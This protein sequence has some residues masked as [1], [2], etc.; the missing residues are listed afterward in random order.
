[1]IEIINRPRSNDF[2]TAHK[3]VYEDYDKF[4]KIPRMIN[5]WVPLIGVT[6]NNM[7]P[8]APRSHLLPENK[9]MRTKAGSTING[10]NYSVNSIKSWD[11][12]SLLTK[13]PLQQDEI[14]I[15]SSHLIHGL[16]INHEEDKTRIS[17]EFRLYVE[18]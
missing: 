7:L 14:L 4:C 13:I 2:N 12:S 15:F 9:I 10:V 5:V 18:A 6:E 17:F 3:D 16:A 1:M 8:I 11:D